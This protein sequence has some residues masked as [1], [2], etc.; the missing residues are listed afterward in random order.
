MQVG[1]EMNASESNC[2]HG[3]GT[4]KYHFQ[5]TTA[6]GRTLSFGLSEMC[7]GDAASTLQSFTESIDDLFM[8]ID[9][10]DNE[11]DFAKL[12]SS[13]KTIMSDLGPVNPVFNCKLKL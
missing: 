3:D 9:S 11:T 1:K 7:G 12:I 6:S 5:I 10:K 2:L 4:S 13:I 8:A